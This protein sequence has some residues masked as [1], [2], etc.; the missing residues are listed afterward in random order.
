MRGD[1]VIEIQTRNFTAIRPKLNIL[2]GNHP[3]LL[4]YPIA[5]V[6]WIVRQEDGEQVSRR[7]SPR[8]GRVEDL[9]YELIYI[10]NLLKHPNLTLEVVFIE[11]EEVRR[12][13]GKGSWRR[14]G[15]SIADRRLVQVL[16]YELFRTPADFYK[17][18]PEKLECP[19]TNHDL[20]KQ[21][22][23]NQSLA[24]RMIYCLQKM[25]LIEFIGKRGRAR[26]FEIIQ[27]DQTR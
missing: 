4:V 11:A 9:F 10:P 16:G 15:W 21:T 8:R 14:Q 3:V 27:R 24:R 7:R 2:L 1:L 12:N 17:L 13:D 6:K 19:F 22:G 18:L 25:N 23:L 20:A 5:K 26:L